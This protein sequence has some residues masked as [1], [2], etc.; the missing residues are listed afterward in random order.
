MNVIQKAYGDMEI[1][2]NNIGHTAPDSKAFTLDDPSRPNTNDTLVTAQIDRRSSSIVIA[3][4]GRSLRTAPAVCIDRFLGGISV[5][6]CPRS[7]PCRRRSTLGASEI[8]GTIDHDDTSGRI[9][10]PGL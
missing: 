5:R 6:A 9:S 2:D 1:L 4:T 7:A 3:Y 8:P 10:Q